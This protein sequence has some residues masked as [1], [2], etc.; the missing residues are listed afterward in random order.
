MFSTQRAHDSLDWKPIVAGI[1]GGAVGTL[2]MGYYWQAVTKISGL[3][4]REAVRREDGTL[5]KLSVVA[6]QTQGDEGSTAAV[7]RVGYEMVM[8][9]KPSD[10]TQQKLGRGVHLGYGSVAGG[11]YGGLRA[12]NGHGADVLGGAAFGTLVWL[13]ASE[14]AM[15]LLGLSAGP[16]K[17]PLRYHAHNLGAHLAYGVTAA[18]TAQQV[19]HLLDRIGR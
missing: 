16:T 10:E 7:G 2:A 14:L 11:L 17:F 19:K 1:I 3:D 8:H 5:D 6:Q 18:L 4:P 12:R 15:P 9:E 13:L